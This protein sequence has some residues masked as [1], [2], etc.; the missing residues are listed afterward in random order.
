MKNT[1]IFILI[2][3]SGVMLYLGITNSI[4]PPVITAIGFIVIALL[5]KQK[6]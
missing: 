1:L 4:A 5:F 6:R 2:L 3:I